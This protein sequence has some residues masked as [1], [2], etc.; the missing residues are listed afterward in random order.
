RWATG[1]GLLYSVYALLQLDFSWP[2]FVVGLG[3]A[4]NLLAR[5]FPPDLGKQDILW[6]G[7]VE[8]LQIAVLASVLGIVLSL[9]LGLLGARNLMPQ[10]VT[11]VARALVAVCRSLHPVIIAIL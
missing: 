9:P 1:A 8:S 2:R 10:P 5:M 11:W 6:S 3:R 4:A 7:M